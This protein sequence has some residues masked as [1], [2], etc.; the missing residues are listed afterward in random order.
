[1]LRDWLY[2]HPTWE[3]AS[4]VVALSV[5]ASWVGLY[6]FGRVVHVSV[7][8]QHNDVAGFVIAIIGVIYAVLLAFIAVAAWASFDSANRVVQQEANLVGNLFR[9]SIAIEEPARTEMRR[10][11]QDYIDLVINREWPAQQAGKVE[12]SAWVSVEKLHATIASIDAKTLSQSVV[13]AEILRTLNDLYSARRSRLLAAQ[14]GIP[15]T[16][17]WIL[18]LGGAITVAFTYFFGM[19]SIRMHYAMTGILA[20]SMALVMVL[21]ISLDWPFRGTVSV[22]PEAFA[23]VQGNMQYQITHSADMRRS[24]A[25]P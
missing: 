18:G 4:T 22:S 20:A 14:D 15:E 21:I 23:A 6:L 17:W 25:A 8:S 7:R 2:N 5:L 10:D 16:I 24:D 1:M 3:M 12:V 19:H 11:L 9:D 13:E